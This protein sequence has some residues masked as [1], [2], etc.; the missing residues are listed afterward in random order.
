MSLRE[1]LD[2]LDRCKDT[3][4]RGKRFEGFLQHLLTEEGF[5]VTRNARATPPLQTDLFAR[6]GRTYF[7]VEAKWL[8]KRL[9]VGHVPAVRDR[10]GYVTQDVFGCVFSMSGYSER[11]VQE[12]CR[13]RTREIILFNGQ[14]IRGVVAGDLSFEELLAEK[15][16]SLRTH[17]D[18][19]FWDWEGEGPPWARSRSGPDVIQL[20]NQT[21]KWLLCSTGRNDLV[22]SN[23]SLDFAG[24]Y[25]GAV[26]SLFMRLDLRS[27]PDLRRLLRIAESQLGLANEG[28]FA[29]HQRDAGWFGFGA[30]SFL[31]AVESRERRYRELGWDTY[32]HSEELGY[33]DRMQTG[34]IF[35]LSSR[36]S[37][38]GTNH[39]H[40]TEIELLMPGIPVEMDRIRRFC[41]LMRNPEAILENVGDYPVKKNG[42]RPE[43]VVEPVAVI[44]SA[45]NSERWASGLVVKNPFLNRK[46]PLA[47]PDSTKEPF[48]L[49]SKQELLFCALRNWHRPDVLMDRYELSLIEGGWI[50]NYPVFWILC[51]WD[52]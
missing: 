9:D 6:R 12:F 41:R 37:T 48:W 10:L 51:D 16:D 3:H 4:E 49:L 32:H 40:A 20:G 11:A 2:D 27:V 8:R 13:D 45:S 24:R 17:A 29:I 42:F 21:R 15:R 18:M 14:E 22:F 43:T 19:W 34:G 1:E 25:R 52:T 33:L 44:V 38:G 28:S 26:L 47:E 30:A 7:L 5:G 35:S 23:E 36:Q 50:G 39:L 31:T 46:A